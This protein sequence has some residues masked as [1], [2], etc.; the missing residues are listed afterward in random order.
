DY[1][2]RASPPPPRGG[3]PAPPAG[4]RART[5]TRP[6]APAHTR[7]DR[8]PLPLK[9]LVAG[10]ASRAAAAR[11]GAHAHA[12]MRRRTHEVATA[13][14]KSDTVSGRVR[15]IMKPFRA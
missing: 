4:T 8:T 10:Q 12:R 15:C 1:F 13:P 3:T 11:P 7:G 2:T 9:G 6:P 5:R 14:P